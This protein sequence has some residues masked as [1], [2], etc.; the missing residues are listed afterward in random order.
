LFADEIFVVMNDLIEVSCVPRLLSTRSPTFGMKNFLICTIAIVVAGFGL[1]TRLA[2]AR[3]PLR[4]TTWNLEHMMSE[5]A[6]ERWRDFCG[7]PQINWDEKKARRAGKPADITFCNVHNGLN[8]PSQRYQEA[9]PLQT[10]EHYAIK[11]AA[12]K[13]RAQK[14]DSDIYALQEVS[15][16]DALARVFAETDYKLFFA[17][18]TDGSMGVGFAVRNKLAATARTLAFD[19]LAICGPE[20]RRVKD[21]PGSCKKGS[22]RSRPGLE[23]KIVYNNRP[24]FLLNVHLKS[25]CRK[26]PLDAPERSAP[27]RVKEA[28]ATLR[29]QVVVMER[30]LDERVGNDE[31]FVIVGDFNR[32]LALELR[33][34]MPAR[35]DGGDPA[36]PIYPDTPIGSMFKE[37][38]D[39][40]PPGAWL[41]FEWQ[42]IAGPKKRTCRR[43]DG[44]TYTVRSCHR[45]IDHFLIRKDVLSR[46]EDGPKRLEARGADY[47]DEGYCAEHARPSDH[48][49]LTIELA[50]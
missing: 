18:P 45:G 22:Y 24:L 26:S 17:G 39:N 6:Y 50:L 7:S 10:P 20:D 43:P 3:P 37:L 34:R 35:L 8:W 48:C 25:S 16:R 2:D 33:S 44:S 32:D 40:E 14:L 42:D 23:L 36:T 29:D 19:D 30:W 46:L 47:G 1:A 5:R 41:V 38:S 49:P 27:A 4:I 11:V 31:D 15:D 9:L 12:L 28:C 13:K 21:D